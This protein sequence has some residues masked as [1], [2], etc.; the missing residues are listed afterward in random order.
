MESFKQ[1]TTNQ[2]FAKMLQNEASIVNQNKYGPGHK[3][4]VRKS[5]NRIVSGLFK[6]EVEISSPT[7]DA[8]EVKISGGS[9]SVYINSGGTVYKLVGTKSSIENSFNHAGG[10]K[11]D[12]NKKTRAKEAI[13]LIVF[14]YYLE[15]GGII[16]EDDAIDQMNNWNADPSVYTTNYY[17]SAVLQLSSFKRIRN[18]KSM[19]FEFQG[20][21]HS[22][23][24]YKKMKDLNGPSSVDN[25]N[26]ADIWLFND[27]YV[28]SMDSELNKMKHLQELNIWLKRNYIKK[29]IIPISL[30]QAS[31]KSTIE[32]I[33]PQKYIKREIEYDL[34][35]T[36]IVIAG[37]LKSVFVETK[38][39]FTFKANARSKETNPNLFYE[40]TMKGENFA[41]GAI[42]KNEWDK[43]SKGEVPSGTS[44]KPTPAL[45]QKAKNTYNAYKRY[46]LLKDNDILFN[47]DISKMDELLQQR[48]IHCGDFLKFI[49]E[50]FDEAMKF[51]FY[52]S[53]KVSENNSMYIKIK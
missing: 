19:I 6:N 35:L 39:G 24:I 21:K 16:G 38:S 9:D 11:S 5:A 7:N 30:K 20:D 17:E 46:I 45:I 49:M 41:M 10:G 48:Y 43:F 36:R 25:W 32:L 29:N 42:S 44:I 51:G 53:M 14:K 40:G 31:G 23:K 4:V 28:N 15:K 26:P 3:L 37:S 34:S 12:T 47:P 27:S 50:N 8:E 52:A 22:A 1:H 13:S 18:L 33:D 2:S